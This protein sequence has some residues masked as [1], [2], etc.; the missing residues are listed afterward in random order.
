MQR[1]SGESLSKLQDFAGIKEL[2][3]RKDIGN[4][5][6]KSLRTNGICVKKKKLRI[7]RLTGAENS[8]WGG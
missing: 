6:C 2:Q 3:E 7:R 1:I 8:K 5:C 4:K